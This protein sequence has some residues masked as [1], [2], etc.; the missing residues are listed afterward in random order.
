MTLPS[1]SPRARP[2]GRLIIAAVTVVTATV[3]LIFNGIASAAQPPVGLGTAASFAVL[4]GQ[5]VTNT[6]PTIISGDVGVSPGSAITGFPPGLITPGTGTFHAADAVA[7]QAQTDLTTAYNDAA[8]RGP[9]TAAP[10]DLGGQTLVAGVYNTAGPMGLTGTVTLDGQNDPN[11]VWIFQA[12]STLITASNSTVALINGASPCNVFWQ[13][14]SSATLGTNTTFVGTIMALTSISAQT[15]TIVEGRLLARNGSV[16]LDNNRIT[17]PNCTIP[18]TS[19]TTA[20][21]TTTTTTAP[22]TTT[23]TT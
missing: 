12:G 3:L 5:T 14:G 15:G 16:T 18:P 13:V 20:P 2:V 17:R 21:P 1:N 6:G 10:P 4:A 11:S 23:T 22:P 9:A 19:T 8:G 7:L